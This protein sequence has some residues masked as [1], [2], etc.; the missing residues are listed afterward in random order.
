LNIYSSRR[1]G[2]GLLSNAPPSRRID[3]KRLALEQFFDPIIISSEVGKGK[4]DP[5]VYRLAEHRAG[6]CPEDIVFVDDKEEYLD[7]ARAGGWSRLIR[8]MSSSQEPSRYKTI[9]SIAELPGMLG[10]AGS[11]AR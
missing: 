8:V 9:G 10:V 3:L 11:S 7:G 1:S 6:V 4:P 5:A 2:W